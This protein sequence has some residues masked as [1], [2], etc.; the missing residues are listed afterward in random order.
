MSN[1][2]NNLSSRPSEAR[3]GTQ[4]TGLGA[5]TASRNLLGPG[6]SLRAAREDS[7]GEAELELARYSEN[8]RKL[9]DAHAYSPD[10]EHD[11]CGVGLVAAIDGKPRR[12]VVLHA[13]EALKCVWHRGAVD[14]D[15]KTGDGAGLHIQVPQ[16]FFA[17]EVKA[18]GHELEGG[19]IGI[20]MIF[21]PRTDYTAQETCRTIVE[22]EILRFGYYIYGW[23]QVPVDISV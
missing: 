15:G 14:A 21:L 9:E 4:E 23:R 13:I 12:D 17:D 1:H 19:R 7:A 2:N 8:A 20:G 18:T 11:A 5:S 22:A 10:Q 16:D 3:A 6:S